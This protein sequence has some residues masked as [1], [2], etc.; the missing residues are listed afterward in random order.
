MHIGLFGYGKMG[1]AVEKQAL[2]RAH[3]T[4]ALNSDLSNTEGVECVIDFSH[5]DT[6]PHAVRAL[7]EN[8]IPVVSGTTGWNDA[9]PSTEQYCTAAK[10]A[11]LWSPNF[12]VGMHMMFFLNSQLAEIMNGH[13]GFQPEILEV[14]HTEKKDSPSGTA[15]ALAHQMLEK[16]NNASGWVEGASSD[17]SVIPIYAQRETDVKG[18]H[19]VSYKS[20]LETLSI[21]HHALSREGFAL[22]AVL[23]A[24][25]IQ[26]KQ[27]NFRFEDVL[28]FP[29]RT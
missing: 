8:G 20:E 18:I 22:G 3:T 12:S 6:S 11:F 28:N 23:A 24:E 15:I 7:L 27:G 16:L 9:I 5:A 29:R 26:G 25:W 2:I 4:V 1:K 13:E 19:R 17:S 10:G 14:H 21:R